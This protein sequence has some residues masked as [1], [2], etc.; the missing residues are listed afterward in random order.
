M[1]VRLPM[2]LGFIR[3]GLLMGGFWRRFA[4]PTCLID[5]GICRKISPE[6]KVMGKR[7]GFRGRVLRWLSLEIEGEAAPILVALSTRRLLST[8]SY[9]GQLRKM[10]LIRLSN[11]KTIKLDKRAPKTQERTWTRGSLESTTT[12]SQ[13]KQTNST[14]AKHE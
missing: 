4:L 10:P 3:R 6:L 2:I 14:T 8:S 5:M 7:G 9:R 13:T 11:E 1:K 12:T